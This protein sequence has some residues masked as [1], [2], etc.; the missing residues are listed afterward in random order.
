MP[1]SAGRGPA[2]AN[3]RGE[4]GA[5]L[6]DGDGPH[7]SRAMDLAMLVL[8]G[9]RERTRGDYAALLGRAGLR[10]VSV[11]DADARYGVIEAVPEESSS[12]AEGPSWTYGGPRARG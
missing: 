5:I 7:P 1:A 2:G 9:G 3:A 6:P 11:R 12:G 10:L 4:P 8:S